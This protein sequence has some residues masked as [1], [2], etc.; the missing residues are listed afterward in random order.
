MI[1]LAYFFSSYKYYP[2]LR[3]QVEGFTQK[4]VSG[5]LYWDYGYGFNELD[6]REIRL[7]ADK[8]KREKPL[9]DVVVEPVFIPGA[10]S[11]RSGIWIVVDPAEN[12]TTYTIAGKH[13]W[14]GKRLWLSP[15]SRIAFHS[16]K[17]SIVLRFFKTLDSGYVRICSKNGPVQIYNLA[18]RNYYG[19]TYVVPYWADGSGPLKAFVSLHTL[20][21]MAYTKLPHQKIRAIR[22]VPLKGQLLT[23]SDAQAPG[24]AYDEIKKINFRINKVVLI[25]H[26]GEKYEY[27]ND[28]TDPSSF[29]TGTI[30]LRQSEFFNGFLFVVQF[31]VAM[32]IGYLVFWVCRLEKFS[33]IRCWRD[34]PV[35]L[36]VNDGIWI[37]W[38]VLAALFCV[39]FLW[40][41]AEWP[42]SMTPDSVTVWAAI[43]KLK[44]DNQH[45]YLYQLLVLG[46]LN[47]YDSPVT[48]IVFQMMC[49]SLLCGLFFYKT[50]RL[51]LKWYFIAFFCL[52]LA[53]SIPINLFN[54]TMWKDIPFALAI[55]FWA[56]FA[57]N[58]RFSSRYQ[59]RALGMKIRDI[60]LL[61]TLFL[62]VCAL[63]H[64]GLVYL[65]FLPAVLF[66]SRAIKPKWIL[67]WGTVSAVLFIL[68]YLVLPPV[69]LVDKPARN[70]MAKRKLAKK[71]QKIGRILDPKNKFYIEDFLAD[72]VKGFVGTMGASPRASLWYNDMYHPPQR[73]FAYDE[74]RAEFLVHPKI[75]CLSRLKRK[76]LTTLR[77]EGLGRGRFVYWNTFLPFLML[78]GFFLLYKWLPASAFFSS[79]VL[80][81]AAVLFFV[82]WPRWRYLYFVYLAGFFIL[83]VALVEIRQKIA[84]RKGKKK[85]LSDMYSSSG[86]A[87]NDLS[88]A[89]G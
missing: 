45:P 85:S 79:I 27:R 31:V 43:K 11:S 86:S 62:F 50:W 7:T 23:T 35:V 3:M 10:K 58:A 51:G 16:R 82:I 60:P 47:V 9:G 32:T 72:K 26:A 63:R 2:G 77:Y 56:F 40:L 75:E 80:Y 12:G 61:A 1:A 88:A 22:F 68:Y 69:V 4:D 59:G 84:M 57:A 76:M 14:R 66:L 74:L 33:E 20:R 39:N 19:Y 73:W 38:L 67:Q 44:I 24:G 83:P 13:H 8:K 29:R 37:F 28:A 53:A 18:G 52:L 65:P 30:S 6:K 46:L 41:L 54:I 64:N 17:N 78:C 15:G 70:Q 42:G 48:V 25:N 5:Y 36:F 21:I 87:P 34:L 89:I 55:L 81:Q 71:V 49:Y